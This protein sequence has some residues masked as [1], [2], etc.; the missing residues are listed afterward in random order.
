MPRPSTR[1][2]AVAY[3]RVSTDE[4]H[5]GSDAQRAAIEHWAATHR[6]DVVGWHV[7][8]GVSGGAA[9]DK[10]DGLLAAL[11]ALAEHRAVVLVVAKH[12]RLARDVL[13]SAMIEQLAN[14]RGARIVSAAGEGSDERD[15]PAGLLMRRV[16]DAFAEY[17][18]GVVRA[19]TRAAMGVKRSRGER[20]GAIPLGYRLADNGR[21]LQRHA[22]EQAALARIRAL[23]AYGHSYATIAVRMNAL[24][25]AARG[26]RWH[27]T[28]VVRALARS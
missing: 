24:G 15:E 8:I 17:E 12:D 5:L 6:A 22:A 28:T 9:I 20:I 25:V 3:L 18:R 1:C 19:R 7:D 21:T 23:R 11:G 10:R 14:R 16:I 13:L 4:Q 26:A 27:K 2:R